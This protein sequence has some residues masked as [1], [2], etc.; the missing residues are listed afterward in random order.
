MPMAIYTVSQVT[1]YIKELVEVDPSLSDIFVQGEV[2]NLRVS[3][4][5]HS[6]FTLKDTSSVLNCVMF[7]SQSGSDL[8]KNGTEVSTHGRLSFYEPRG[9]MDYMVDLAMPEGTGKLSLELEQLKIRLEASGLFEE[10]RKRPLPTFPQTVGVV[11]S[12]SGSV[13]HDIQNVISRRYPLAKILL[14]PSQVQGD[15]AASNIVT[16]LELL[17]L[18][19]EA[20]VIIVARGGG[21]LEELWPFNEEIV[22]NAIFGS[23]IP[24]ISA[25]GHETDVTISDLVADLRAPTPSAAAELAVPDKSV[26]KQALSEMIMRNYNFFIQQTEIFKRSISDITQKLNL[27]IPDLNLLRRQIDDLSKSLE[28]TLI[29]K[30]NLTKVELLSLQ[31]RLQTLDP[32]ATLQRGY[33]V[34][35]KSA[36]GHVVLS[37]KDVKPGE[38]LN[39][40]LGDGMLQVT[41]TEGKMP[42]QNKSPSPSQDQPA[43]KPLI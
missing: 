18:N 19:G 35:Q 39:V 11:T 1:S 16:A 4:A 13:F 10:S 32:T 24:V 17:N 2:S 7:R 5:G 36:T 41:N 43:M 6:Y 14:S 3:S 40:T 30:I 12:P 23:R 20:D 31:Q 15:S 37:T 34:V 33:A 38:Q 29:G 22:A 27:S 9:S 26:L 42:K 21:S 25:V 8:L 28:T